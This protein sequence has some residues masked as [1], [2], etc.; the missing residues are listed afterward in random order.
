MSEKKIMVIGLGYIGNYAL[1]FLARTQGID[2]IIAA[3]IDEATGQSKVYNTI[4]GAAQMGF[5]PDMKFIPL[6]LNNVEETASVLNKI[7]PDVIF[8]SVTLQSWWV[9]SDLPADLY[10]KFRAVAG[11]GPWLPM[12]LVPSYKLMKAVKDA[13]IKTHVVVAGFPDAVCPVLGK[14][15]LALLWVWGI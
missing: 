4:M 2:T 14:V 8:S 1:E 5:Y 9:I 11:Y 10:K 3:D 15:G 6:D 12:H 13:S 7:A